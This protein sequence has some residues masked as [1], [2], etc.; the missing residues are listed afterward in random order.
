[1]FSENQYWPI[2]NTG[3]RWL[4]PSDASEAGAGDMLGKWW[5]NRGQWQ[6][7]L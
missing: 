6:L 1:M 3:W 4:I 2:A 5:S 7:F